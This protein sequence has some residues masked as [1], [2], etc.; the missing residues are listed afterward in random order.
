MPKVNL[1]YDMSNLIITDV[2]VLNKLS[3]LKIDKSPGPDLI[4]PRILKE[5]RTQVSKPLADI[6]RLSLKDGKLPQ[7][8]MV[9]DVTAIHKKGNKSSVNNYRP[10]SLTSI[11]CKIME[12]IIRDHIIEHFTKNNLFS[13]KQ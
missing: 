3:K 10:I 7:D 12:S 2:M 4:H 11:P 1:A 5:I 6:F 9:S 13:K 8:W